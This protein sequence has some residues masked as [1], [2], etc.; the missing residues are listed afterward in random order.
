MACS[1]DNAAP[2]LD[3]SGSGILRTLFNIVYFAHWYDKAS[4]L[5]AYMFHVL[6]YGKGEFAAV[7]PDGSLNANSVSYLLL[8]RLLEGA[9]SLSV[10]ALDHDGRLHGV[11]PHH[12]KTISPIVALV[13]NGSSG[14]RALVV[15][16]GLSDAKLVLPFASAEIRSLGGTPSA[17]INPDSLR[18]LDDI[19]ARTVKDRV[20]VLPPVSVTLIER[21][22]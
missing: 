9:D 1:E 13:S 5:R 7:N 20:L 11:G 2:L 15:N 22:S 16:L 10:Q 18:S 21:A 17:R 8:H 6:D 14:V 12:E 3:I 4:N 19:P